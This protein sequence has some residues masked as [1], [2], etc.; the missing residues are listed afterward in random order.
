[1]K[2]I[3]EALYPVCLHLHFK[4]PMAFKLKGKDNT[5]FK[6]WIILGVLI[7]CVATFFY[8]DIAQYLTLAALKENKDALHSYMDS[9]Y[10]STVVVFVVVYCVQTALSLP[11]AAIL[12]LAGGFLFGTWWG[13]IY[14]NLG[15]TSGA[16]L[17]F[18]FVRYL[19]RDMVEQRFGGRIEPILQGF[20]QN[21]FHYLLTL[22]LIPLFPFFLVNLACGLTRVSLSTYAGATAIGI[23]P[24]SLV[25]TNAG[26]QLG[27]IE[28]ARDIASPGVLLAFTLLGLLSL[29]PV[30]Y[31][32]YRKNSVQRLH[33]G[34]K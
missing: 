12:T 21:A 14:V 16:V 7:L 26:R 33:S 24:G 32:K 13:T 23:L 27:A 22:R 8:F 29:T 15:A 19:F 5:P 17:A 28:S 20:T 34:A 2:N 3:G 11:G 4:H 6:K 10:L 9:N 1:M 25:Y 31:Q 18:L 30:V